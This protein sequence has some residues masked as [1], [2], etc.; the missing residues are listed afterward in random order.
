[1]RI[2]LNPNRSTGRSTSDPHR[3]AKKSKP[4]SGSFSD[5]LD[6]GKIPSRTFTA[7]YSHTSYSHT[8]D[9]SHGG[10]TRPTQVGGDIYLNRSR[11]QIRLFS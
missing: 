2:S 1:M 5:R 4:P 8:S 10:T 3:I 9:P 7:L 11:D 6:F